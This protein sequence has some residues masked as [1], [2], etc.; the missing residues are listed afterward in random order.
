MICST[1]SVE[2][3]ESGRLVKIHDERKFYAAPAPCPECTQLGLLH[4]RREIESSRLNLDKAKAMK[5]LPGKFTVR[6]ILIALAWNVCNIG[7]SAFLIWSVD[8]LFRSGYIFSG[9]IVMLLALVVLI[10]TLFLLVIT[11]WLYTDV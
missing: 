3:T 10:W 8:Q 6:N 5:S 9:M 2:T 1:C 11:I 4:L 7:A